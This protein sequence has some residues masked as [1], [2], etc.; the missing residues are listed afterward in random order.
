MGQDLAGMVGEFEQALLTLDRLRARSVL[1]SAPDAMT[2]IQVADRV[3]GPALERIGA[4]WEEGRVALSQVYMS[5]R[6]CEELIAEILP[7][8]SPDRRDRPKMAIAVLQDHHLLG[9]RIVYSALRAAGYEIS[10]YGRVDV[11]D[12]VERIRADGVRILLI[13]TL[14]LNS[15]LRIKEVRRRLDQAGAEVKIIV[16]GAPFRFDT[17]LWRDVGADAMGYTATDAITVINQITG[18]A[19]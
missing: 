16:G 3:A 18:G 17:Y 6:I 13:S 9:K 14:M 10:D 1:V 12:L 11:F 7:P 15:A 8:D 5:G 4:G 19:Q 2:A